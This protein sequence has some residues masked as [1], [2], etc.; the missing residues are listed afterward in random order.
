M[1]TYTTPIIDREI[2]FGNPIIAGGQISPDGEYIS[3]IK[4]LDGMM[5][6]W[7]KP[8]DG[9][10][11]NAVPVTNDKN[12]PVTSYFW[13]RDSKYILYVQDKGGD[14]NYHLYALDPKEAFDNKMPV[15]RDLSDYGDI[16]AMIYSLPRSNHK[17]IY[18]GINDRDKAWH[19]CYEIDLESGE[20]KLIY[21]NDEQLSG[22]YFD[23]AGQ[24]RLAGKSTAD[25]GSEILEIA[26]AGLTSILKATLEES[27]SPIKFNKDGQVYMLSN[28]GEPDLT[29]LYTYDFSTRAM[30]LLESDPEQQVDIS[31]VSFSELTEELIATVYV[32]DKKRI[33]WKDSKHEQTYKYLKGEFPGAE[34]S[35]GSMTKDESKF[36]FFVNNDTDP[37]TAYL[38]YR[39]TQLIEYLYTPRP[40]L[41]TDHLSE[42]QPVRFHSED[43]LEIPGY[44]TLPKTEKKTG[45][46]AVLFIHGGPWARDYWGYNSFAQFLANRGYATL[47]INF[48]GSTG[49]GKKFLNAAINQWGEKMQDDLTAGAK[50]LVDE[51]IADPKRI[52]I[53][54]GS[55]GGY[56]TLAG[57]TFT[58]DVYAAGVSIVGPSN[59]FTLLDT[60]PPYW[61]SARTMF[62]KRMG[63]PTTEEGRAQLRRQSPFFHAKN[64]KAPLMV[65]QG[66]NDPRVKTSES[67][68]IVIA[69]RDLGLPVTYLNFPDEGHGFANPENNMAFLSAME[70][71]LAQHLGGRHQEEIPSR[72]EK[73][74]DKVTVDIAALNM[75]AVVTDEMLKAPLPKPTKELVPGH[76][77]YDLQFDM[78]GQVM[79]FE[80][81]RKITK[82]GSDLIIED[83]SE[84]ASGNMLDRSRVAADTFS[85]QSRL[86]EQGPM[87]IAYTVANYKVEG[88]LTMPN[89]ENTI[90]LN[91]D[92]SFVMDG[93]SLDTYLAHLP[94]SEGYKT[95]LRI[96]DSTNQKFQTYSFEVLGTED[97]QGQA[98]YKCKLASIDG[99]EKSQELWFSTTAAPL[100]MLKTSVIKEMGG[101]KLRVS[102]NRAEAMK[103]SPLA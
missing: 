8:L 74:L 50:F 70:K 88:T 20:R 60:I 89:G 39:A 97:I 29:G 48:R 59:L 57:L 85:P 82:D 55:Y 15:A 72:L 36:I 76:L 73:I 17:V 66:D 58:P 77:I 87:K 11:E 32:G 26:E 42:M 25:G 35:I 53:A 75:P 63:D 56:A 24:L 69:M 54:G 80:V 96:L 23:Q 6:I 5:N 38:Y 22:F 71:F 3:F 14:E 93:P 37:G 34:I 84:S 83:L 46:P 90:E 99:D 27:I 103:D 78:N 49:Y 102:F 98:C 21:Q 92:F 40:E 52:A 41:P 91:P 67:D 18:V 95:T 2:L 68:Q 9:A 65:A 31:N 62:H 28:V 16:R 19:D 101:A 33:Y 47:Q 51:G 81:Q 7:V 100:M 79:A 13:S 61:E 12:R 64:I 86:F 44:L 10:F 4:P 45:L 30:E 1:S 43:G 94:L